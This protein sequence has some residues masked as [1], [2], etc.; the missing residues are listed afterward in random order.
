MKRRSTVDVRTRR[1]R[2]AVDPRTVRRRALKLLDALG[3]TR[4]ELS[5][6]LCDDE[7]IHDLNRSYRDVDRPTDVLA[8]PLLG[9]DD[10]PPEV[11]RAL[12]DVV[13]SVETAARQAA[14][15]RRELL[16]EVTTLLV[17]GVLHL[18]GHDHENALE[19][20]RMEE[21]TE[22]LEQTLFSRPRA[23]RRRPIRGR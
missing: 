7:L 10:D 2:G 23:D 8:F 20:A 13:I 1:I 17:H 16:A 18:L 4:A 21:L 3:E 19:R 6:L 14:Q 5:I 11:P 15:R 9:E 12:G 22:R